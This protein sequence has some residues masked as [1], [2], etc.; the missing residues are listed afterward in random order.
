MKNGIMD[1]DL[2]RDFGWFWPPV[3]R[4]LWVDDAMEDLLYENGLFHQTEVEIEEVWMPKH[5]RLADDA[6]AY[7][8]WQS[9]RS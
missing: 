4:H 2:V 5:A 3:F 6:K 7:R 1:G 9:L 8:Q